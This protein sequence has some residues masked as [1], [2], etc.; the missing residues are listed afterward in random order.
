MP[1]YIHLC[2]EV[3]GQCLTL[4]SSIVRHNLE[5]THSTRLADQQVPAI[6]LPPPSQHWYYGHMPLCPALLLLLFNMSAGD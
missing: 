1:M 6:S 3:K 2:A 5:L 4:S